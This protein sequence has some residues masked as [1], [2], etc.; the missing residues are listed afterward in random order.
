MVTGFWTLEERKPLV[1]GFLHG[2]LTICRGRQ[3]VTGERLIQIPPQLP[4]GDK[5]GTP[6]PWDSKLQQLD[7][8]V[9]RQWRLPHSTTHPEC[10][11][12]ERFECVRLLVG[13]RLLMA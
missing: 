13:Y 12:F 5:W 11:E 1:V 3:R 10:Q 8:E 4:T 6:Q 9:A 7:P 2:M